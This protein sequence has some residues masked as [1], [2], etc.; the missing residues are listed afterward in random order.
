MKKLIALIALVVLTTS[1]AFADPPA[2]T[3]V[4]NYAR[5][6]VNCKAMA[7]VC[8]GDAS[9][10]ISEIGAG[11]TGTASG[12]TQWDISNNGSVDGGQTFT[13]A[14]GTP[15]G[16]VTGTPTGGTASDLTVA[17]L[18]PAWT[19]TD[20]DYNSGTGV[21]KLTSRNCGATGNIKYNYLITAL[22]TAKPGLYTV[23][24]TETFTFL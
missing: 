24:F 15:F 2:P 11:S 7:I 3:S 21:C 1:F 23:T 18:S 8:H 17:A 6:T 19:Y 5:V 13:H 14:N 22:E 10:T 9:F 4:P 16:T 20:I 12:Y